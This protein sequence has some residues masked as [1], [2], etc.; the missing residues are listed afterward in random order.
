MNHRRSILLLA[1]LSACLAFAPLATAQAPGRPTKARESHIPIPG[2][3]SASAD[4]TA[5]LDGILNEAKENSFAMK[6]AEEIANHPEKYK[7]DF[8]ALKN[9]YPKELADIAKGMNLD[10]KDPRL[11][12]TMRLFVKNNKEFFK[13]NEDT[14]PDKLKELQGNQKKIKELQ[15]QIVPLVAPPQEG[16]SSGGGP[17]VGNPNVPFKGPQNPNQ[18]DAS[19]PP[20][21]AKNNPTQEPSTQMPPENRA[22]SEESNT[23]TQRAFDAGKTAVEKIEGLVG[24]SV[25]ISAL[26]GRVKMASDAEG[27]SWWEKRLGMNADMLD[28]LGQRLNPEQ[29]ASKLGG[30]IPPGMRMPSI[31]L[32]GLQG[33]YSNVAQASSQAAQSD[34]NFSLILILAF[35]G[36]AFLVIWRGL[37]QRNEHAA[38][39]ARFNLGPWPVTP[40]QVRSGAELIKAFEYLSLLFLGRAARTL[41]HHEIAKH[42]GQTKEI[43]GF[44]QLQ[45]T[46]ALAAL[47]EQARYAPWGAALP[48]SDL[49]MARRHLSLLAGA[50]PA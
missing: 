13:G 46:E 41:N 3:T 27:N 44:E 33:T 35:V 15:G 50:R 24:D 12:E 34:K 37:A 32:G 30:I 8:E 1:L 48:E 9:Q 21:Q 14:L 29:W 17:A 49:S 43:A 23:L 16:S 2:G 4:P 47:Y 25:D 10:P 28:R 11:Q 22:S 45:A 7:A 36:I 6:L 18:P 5:F 31:S 39:H 38:R 20:E 40:G 19:N 42:L 26:L